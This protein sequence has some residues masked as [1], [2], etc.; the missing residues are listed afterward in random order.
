MDLGCC[1]LARLDVPVILVEAIARG[2]V[3][4]YQEVY[5]NEAEDLGMDTCKSCH[6]WVQEMRTNMPRVRHIYIFSFVRGRESSCTGASRGVGACVKG[7]N[8]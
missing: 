6:P 1:S 5:D 7:L 3:F 8:S 4:S 2:M